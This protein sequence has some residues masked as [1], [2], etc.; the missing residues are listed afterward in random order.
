MV[1]LNNNSNKKGITLIALVITIIILL[2]LATISISMLTGNNSIINKTI[3][4]KEGSEISEEKEVINLSVTKSMSK[5]KYGNLDGDEFESILNEESNRNA[6][7]IEI[8]DN[9]IT[10]KFLK[11]GRYYEID[12][13]G[14]ITESEVYTD[15]TPGQLAGSG[16]EENPFKI[17]CIEDLVLFSKSVNTGTTYTGKYVVLVRDLNFKSI[18]SYNNHNAKYSYIEEDN[19][20]EPDENSETTIK[21]LCTTGQGFIPI[22]GGTRGFG[23]IFDGK[24]NNKNHEIRNIYINNNNQIVALFGGGL[25]TAKIKNVGITGEIITLSNNTAAGIV[26]STTNG[27]TT[28]EI[29]NCYNKANITGKKYVAGIFGGNGVAIIKKCHNSGTIVSEYFV[30]GIV[31]YG[32][33]EIE[34]CYNEGKVMSTTTAGGIVGYGGWKLNR[35]Y[36]TGNITGETANGLSTSINNAINCYNTGIITGSIAGRGLGHG[37]NAK[38]CYNGG[39]VNAG[40]STG[41]KITG[42]DNEASLTVNCC[43]FGKL[44][45]NGRGLAKSV[46][47]NSGTITNCYYLD[48][49]EEGTE[50]IPEESA[51]KFVKT[52][53]DTEVMTTAKV[54]QALNAYI[55]SN[56]D[57]E[58]TTG[59]CKW[60]VSE[61]NLPILDYNTEWN[62]IE[63]ITKN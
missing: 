20:Y 39:I 4:A 42:I 10:V 63:W 51:I 41:A 23:G 52:S 2:I 18:L 61:D 31:G 60:K 33:G 27:G 46:V 19:A 55:E 38:N 21:E 45:L 13:D 25:R 16:T 28:L 54:V 58:N 8:D 40:T 26:A 9:L 6:E 44:N 1:V 17:E 12:K 62:G 47:S 50:I 49:I 43:S 35:C 7:V 37:G 11:S 14:N 5:N 36:N 59:W 15:T 34:D 29:E 3:I 48:G 53:N 22:G 32:S 56:E 30:G 57:E 24:Y